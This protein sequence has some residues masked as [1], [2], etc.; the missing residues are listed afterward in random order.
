MFKAC[1]EQGVLYVPGDYCMQ[2]GE[3]GRVATNHLRLS[4]GQV[5]LEKIDAGIERLAGVIA[6]QL[7]APAAERVS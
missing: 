6:G 1:V 5:A 7:L 3:D 4:F 2:A